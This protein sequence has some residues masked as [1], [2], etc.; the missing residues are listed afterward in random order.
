MRA[1]DLLSCEGVNFGSRLFLFLPFTIKIKRRGDVRLSEEKS[2]V[3]WAEIEAEYINSGISQKALADKY[4]IKLSTLQKQS[5]K[6]KW[7]EKRQRYAKKKRKKVTD[8]LHDKDVRKTVKDIERVCDAAGRLIEKVNRA[9][10]QLDKQTYI[11]LDDLKV[12]TKEEV[13]EES[14]R[15][16]QTK[17]RKMKTARMD[18]LIDTKR[19]SEISRTLRDLKE[20]LTG[21]DGRAED[22]ENS[23]IIEIGAQTQI[24]K[25][26]DDNENDMDAAA[27]AG[28]DDVT[29]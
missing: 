27:E 2:S 21:E 17:R 8:K 23:G 5:A 22:A 26:E 14:S 3:S 16:H 6:G 24:D 1:T 28:G 20:I 7:S 4:G 12:E 19:M 18:A 10:N 29:S 9:I 25:R 13:S 11:T 15:F